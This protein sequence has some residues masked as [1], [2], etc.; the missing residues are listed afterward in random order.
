MQRTINSL[1]N[2]WQDETGQ[3]VVEYAL[4]A[5]LVALS[6]ASEMHSFGK[7]MKKDYNTIG[8]DFVKHKQY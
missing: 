4:L 6:V 5:A 7:T 8:N 2:L 3:D 1:K